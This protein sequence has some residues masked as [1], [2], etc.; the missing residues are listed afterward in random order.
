MDIVGQLDIE[1]FD[2]EIQDQAYRNRDA[3]GEGR[4][5]LPVETDPDRRH[6]R[7]AESSPPE[8]A[9][10]ATSRAFS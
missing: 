6:E 9:E 5:A 8:R 7:G 2:G 1:H 4:G 3:R 10:S